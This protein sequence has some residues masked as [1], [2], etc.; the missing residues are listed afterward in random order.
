[1]TDQTHSEQR[2]SRREGF[3]H[4]QAHDRKANSIRAQAEGFM[5]KA[6]EH[7]RWAQRWRD[8]A[9]DEYGDVPYPGSRS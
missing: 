8:W 5:I 6:R 2:V 1:M 4:A 9:D 3:E 7:E